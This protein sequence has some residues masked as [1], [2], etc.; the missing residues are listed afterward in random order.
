M[1]RYIILLCENKREIVGNNSKQILVFFFLSMV[2]G[3]N[4]K[5]YMYYALSLQIELN[6]R[7]QTNC[8]RKHI[9]LPG[10]LFNY[11]KN[12]LFNFTLFFSLKKKTSLI[13]YV[14]VIVLPKSDHVRLTQTKTEASRCS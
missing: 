4:S 5:P 3:S 10:V 7:E 14:C 2:G 8:L 9:K 6:S 12:I 11:F 13:F 1:E